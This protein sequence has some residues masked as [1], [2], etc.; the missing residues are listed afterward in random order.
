MTVARDSNPAMPGLASYPALQMPDRDQRTELEQAHNRNMMLA[1]ARLCQLHGGCAEGRALLVET[2]RDGNWRIDRPWRQL[3]AMM[4]QPADYQL[5]RRLWLTSPSQC[6][7]HPS[8]LRAV[9]RAAAVS[10]NHHDCRVLLRKLIALHKDTKNQ[11]PLHRRV[12]QKLRR[13]RPDALGK[14]DAAA[15]HER[16]TANAS[17]ALTDLNQAF[18]HLGLN[19]F[20]VSGTLLGYLREGRII[21]WDKDIDVGFFSEQCSTDLEA[22]FRASDT[23]RVG[24]VDLTTDRLRL[25]HANG[26]MIDVFPHY[27]EQGCRWHDG[28]ATRWWNTPFE[29]KQIEFLGIPQYIPDPPET[30]LEE[31]YGGWRTPVAHFDARMDAGNV[32]ITDYPHYVSLLYFSLET[33]IRANDAASANRYARLLREY[34]ERG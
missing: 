13:L 19:V 7:T 16:F 5:I 8:I 24:R 17:R 27:M 31:N 18:D 33:G 11:R 30:Y 10:G 1:R 2:I 22:H 4:E 14:T 26:V 23:F 3:V 34:H 15:E 9:A 12:L 21:G 32:E 20:L 29:L 6:H 25:I 28:A